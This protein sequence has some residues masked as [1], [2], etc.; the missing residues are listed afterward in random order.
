MKK[1][2]KKKREQPPEHSDEAQSKLGKYMKE[3]RRG[4]AHWHGRLDLDLALYG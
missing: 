3:G 2:G 4:G 1:E